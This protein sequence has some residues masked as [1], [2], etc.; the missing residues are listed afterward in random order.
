MKIVYSTRFNARS[1][2]ADFNT[3]EKIL[4]ER[5]ITYVQ[6]ANGVGTYKQLLDR[7]RKG[8]NVSFT[9]LIRIANYLDINVCELLDKEWCDE[10]KYNQGI[11]R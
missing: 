1:R 9:L 2:L 4:H 5:N 6:L 3:L 11:D 7:W 8:S 10:L